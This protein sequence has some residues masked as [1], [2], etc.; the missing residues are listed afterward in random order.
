MIIQSENRGMVKNGKGI[1]RSFDPTSLLKQ[2]PTD[3][4]ALDH[5]HLDFKCLQGW[6]LYN[7]PGQSVP[8]LG[9]PTL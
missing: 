8:G 7:I 5:V 3:L 4:V 6:I 9:D 1:W 2:I